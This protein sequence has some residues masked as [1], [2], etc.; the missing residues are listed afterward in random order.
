M[1][2]AH[3]MPYDDRDA[4]DM[5]AVADFG[6]AGSPEVAA[7]APAPPIW[8]Q[9]LRQQRSHWLPTLALVEIAMLAFAVVLAMWAASVTGLEPMGGASALLFVAVAGAAMVGLGLYQ[10]HSGHMHVLGIATATRVI[11]ALAVAALVSAGWGW[12]AGETVAAG[13]LMFALVYG[14]VVMLVSRSAFER[15]RGDDDMRRRTLFLGAGERAAGVARSMRGVEAR[16]LRR[17]MQVE[18]FVALPSDRVALVD[19]RRVR[20]RGTLAEYARLNDI[21]EIVTIADDGRKTLPYPDLAACQLAGVDVLDLASFY[22]REFGKAALDLIAPSWCVQSHN[23]NNSALRRISKRGFDVAMAAVL[24]LLT[25]PLMLLVVAAIFVESRGRGPLLYA[26]ER[27]GLGGVPFLLYKFRSMRTDAE[28][29]GVAR[30]AQTADDRVT[31]VGRRIRKLRLDE[32]PQLWNVL[33]GEMSIVGPRPERPQFVDGF[34]QRVPHYALRHSVRPGLT[35]WAQLRF[36]YGASEE[37]AVEKLRYDL[38]Y[39]KF[40]SLRF[41]LLIG[42]QTVE[43]VLFGNGV[44]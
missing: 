1:N 13:M 23:F 14:G 3:D 42:L 22:E 30:W 18:G 19:S 24:L 44:R 38:Y 31:R 10:R 40:H 8:R 12:L 41:D 20:L 9:M 25:W 17:S 2:H 39:V 15:I 35:G 21:D 33:K 26:Q 16:P 32:L 36:P 34:N 37:D 28:A 7:A 29:D 43:V 11:A 5:S 6:Y 27:V 4:S